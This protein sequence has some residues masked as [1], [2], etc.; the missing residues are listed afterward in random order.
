MNPQIILNS[1]AHFFAISEDE[2]KGAKKPR[3]IAEAR[4]VYF[5]LSRRLTKYSF[6]SIGDLVNKDH[7]T[8]MHGVKSCSQLMDVYPDFRDQVNQLERELIGEK[9]SNVER[10]KLIIQENR[11]KTA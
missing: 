11:L 5:Y 10:V 2:I 4:K 3:P 1:V 7:A 9:E 6:N 8:V